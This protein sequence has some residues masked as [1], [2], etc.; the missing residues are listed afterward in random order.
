M[1]I[2]SPTSGFTILRTLLQSIQPGKKTVLRSHLLFQSQTILDFR[3]SA[4]VRLHLACSVRESVRESKRSSTSSVDFMDCEAYFRQGIF[5]QTH[6][7]HVLTLFYVLPYS[8]P[9]SSPDHYPAPAKRYK[10]GTKANT[11]CSI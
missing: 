6:I 8:K 1:K 10:F 11:L 4:L 9:P 5:S 7:S 3:Y 2:Y